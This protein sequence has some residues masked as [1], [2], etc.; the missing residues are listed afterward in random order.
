MRQL[1]DRAIVEEMRRLY[2]SGLSMRKVAKILGVSKS[3]VSMYC[4][5]CAREPREPIKCDL[6]QSPDE[7]C[8]QD[9]DPK[10]A[11]F[12][13]TVFQ[14]DICKGDWYS[15][16]YPTWRMMYEH[17]LVYGLEG[18]VDF[19]DFEDC[20]QPNCKLVHG[21]IIGV[22]DG[23]YVIEFLTDDPFDMRELFVR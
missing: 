9:A 15:D 17:C 21:K 8:L 13:I 1:I 14:N 7:A 18:M 3:A 6:P 20:L 4:G 22:D 11:R 23:R 16:R 10:Y 19:K 2:Q 5:S 12:H